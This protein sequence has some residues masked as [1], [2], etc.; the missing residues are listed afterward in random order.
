MDRLD[1]SRKTWIAAALLVGVTIAVYAAV[2]GNGFVVYDDPKY[3]TGNPEVR[4]GLTLAGLEWAW[5][6]GHASNWHP[7]TWM[8]HMLDQDLFGEGP[9][10]QH[11]TSLFLHAANTLLLFLLLERTTGSIGRSAFVA[12]LFGVHPLHVESVAWISERKDVL[13]TFFWLL[14]TLAYVRWTRSPSRPRYLLVVFLAALGL[15]SKPMVVTLPF[16]LLLLDIWPLARLSAGVRALVLEKLPLFALSAASCIVTFL[17]QRAGGAMGSLDRY[18]PATRM[19]NACISVGAYL[20]KAVWPRDLAVYYPYPTHAPAAWRIAGVIVLVVLV[21]ALALRERR[22]RPYLLVG[23]LWFL[24]T[25]VP[26]I[27]LVQVGIQSM[28]DRYTYVPLT[29]IFIMVAWGVPDLA[30]RLFEKRR[31]SLARWLAIPGVAAVLALAGCTWIQVGYWRDSKTLFAHALDVTTD[32]SIAHADLGIALATEGKFE[33]AIAHY[34]ESL[35]I[36]PGHAP[37]LHRLGKALKRIGHEDEA[38][39][40]FN[41]AL[42]GDPDFADARND[43]GLLLAGQGKVQEAIEQFELVLRVQPDDAQA[44]YNLGQAL[45]QQ[46]HEDDAR[47]HFERALSLDSDFAGA[48]ASLGRLLEAEGKT[49]EA[50][51][52]FETAIR[53]DPA[54]TSARAYLEHALESRNL[55]SSTGSM[56]FDPGTGTPEAPEQLNENGVELARGGRL[57]EAIEQFRKAIARKPDLTRAHVN[58]G[59]ALADKGRHADAVA[60]YLKALELD[61]RNPEAHANLGAS[62]VELG[63]LPEAISHYEE[64]IRERARYPEALNNLGSALIATGRVD[65]A[66]DRLRV[67]ISLRPDYA[68]AHY[69]LAVALYTKNSYA[70]A[71]NEIRTAR[72][73]G[74]TPPERFLG[75][76]AA[77]MPEP[78]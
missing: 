12:A 2:A 33:E 31:E 64:A 65:D 15:A 7:V 48:H 57:D 37:T 55:A 21:S 39:A 8:S 46:G 9:A 34:R 44:Y 42:R 36:R 74:F 18:T 29:G 10:G 28:A 52:H 22:R 23:W 30:A 50:I 76:L 78:R 4:R 72:R 5:T 38:A 25:L 67:A 70:D 66:C 56:P 59:L 24:G 43:L 20:R 6:T 41:E 11:L 35:R 3:V 27:G 71:W 63:R 14:A 26:V 32:N 77:R 68:K 17:V 61:P 73:L 47:R 16:T 53:I 62:L 58:L 45:A 13:S 40:S 54:D 49:R 69:N 1:R 51:E 60:S 19:S 75:M